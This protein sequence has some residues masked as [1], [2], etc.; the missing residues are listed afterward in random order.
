VLNNLQSTAKQ[1]PTILFFPGTYTHS[2]EI[3]ASLDLF[4]RL[5]DDKYYRAFNILHYNVQ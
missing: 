5:R 1:Q 2:P 4:G 3:G